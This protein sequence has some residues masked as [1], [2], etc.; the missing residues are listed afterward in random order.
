MYTSQSVSLSQSHQPLLLPR[1]S[2]YL[3]WK[4]VLC[5]LLTPAFLGAF[6]VDSCM[7]NWIQ[8]VLLSRI[9]PEEIIEGTS[10]APTPLLSP[11][12][13]LWDPMFWKKE[14]QHVKRVTCANIPQFLK[15]MDIKLEAHS[16][17]RA[18]LSENCSLLGTDN[19]RE[20]IC[21]HIF[22]SNEGYCLY[23]CM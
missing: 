11:A 17:P 22:A 7:F 13:S 1:W 20:Q 14:K 5:F 9:F 12:F 18:S 19:V 21:E 8:F 3:G 2:L 4:K 16:F 6:K 10:T 23:I 15:P